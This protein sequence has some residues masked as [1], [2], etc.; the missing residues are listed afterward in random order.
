MTHV[1]T[2]EATLTTKGRKEPFTTLV[3]IFDRLLKVYGYD[4]AFRSGFE[5]HFREMVRDQVDGDLWSALGFDEVVGLTRAHIIFP[6]DL[7][8]GELPVL[9]PAETLIVGLSC[10]PAG[11]EALILACRHLKEVGYELAMDGF[12]AKH[13]ASAFLDFGDIVRVD[14]TAASPEEQ[15]RICRELPDRGIRALAVNVNTPEQFDAARDAG[16]WY[17]QGD[18]FRCPVF[19]PDRQ[20]PTSKLQYLELLNAVNRLE[21]AY[22]NLE[23]LIKQDVAMTYRLL[24]FINS[25]WY[26]LR[27]SVSS[28]RHALVLLGP[29]QVRV[30]ASMLVL[31]DMGSGKPNE[32]FRRCLIRGRMAELVA[33]SVGMESRASELFLMGMFSLADALT[34]IPIEKVLEALPLS[35]DV[36]L[37]LR[38]NAGDFGLIYEMVASYELGLWETFS[39]SAAAIELDE[40]VVPG[41]F[42]A[43]RKW[44]DQALGAIL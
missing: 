38:G 17:F 43:A 15:Q 4:L 33:P 35:Q 18:F 6:P 5:A 40:D 13:L 22:D 14:T 37:A 26:G 20:I 10:D 41:I 27:R 11:D 12:R 36:K 44:A 3:P 8:A 32:L 42:G 21:L 7:V 2:T 23:E 16:F 31:K 34:D 30:W 29:A 9:F 28:I 19:Q 25:A 39:R 1:E 24:R